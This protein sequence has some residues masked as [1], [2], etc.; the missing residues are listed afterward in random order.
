M[1]HSCYAFLMRGYTNRLGQEDS[2]PYFL[3]NEDTSLSAFRSIIADQNEIDWA[4]YAG[5]LLREA[6]VEDVWLFLTPSEV[7]KAWAEISP[8]LGH[9]R[10]F[11][12]F[13]LDVWQKNGV[14]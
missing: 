10:N 4:I 9:R 1:P 3:W 8:Y 6:R 7:A 2:A 12:K 5:R 11:W 14:L 13:L